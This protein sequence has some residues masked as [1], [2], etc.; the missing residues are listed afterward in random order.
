MNNYA[1]NGNSPVKFVR[2][3]RKAK[4][5]IKLY[6]I[7]SKLLEIMG[8]EFA[9]KLWEARESYIG[10]ITRN[11]IIKRTFRNINTLF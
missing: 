1:A 4:A 11:N 5:Q 3:A 7:A 8:I 10:I 9:Y 2:M 6:F